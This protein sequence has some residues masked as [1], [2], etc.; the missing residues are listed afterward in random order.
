MAP[1]HALIVV[2][3]P[4][5]RSLTHA[6]AQAIASGLEA[7]PG[8]TV[9]YADLAAERFQPAFG[10]A[11]RTTYLGQSE[12]PADVLREQARLDKADALVLVFPVYWWSLPGQLKGWIDR[13]FING[14][15]FMEAA[16]GAIDKRLQRLDV[17]LVGLAGAEAR[18]Y[19]RHGYGQA[20]HAQVAHGIFEF[21]GA[22]VVTETLLHGAGEAAIH[23]HLQR[24]RSIG[25]GLPGRQHAQPQP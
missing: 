22:R 15:A 2:S 11:D 4:D 19:G 25:A 14:W 20:F 1:M 21:C 10:P 23:E 5:P 6:V 7:T 17:H 9:E 13:V 16:D 8:H 18:T 3:H 24:A 12:P